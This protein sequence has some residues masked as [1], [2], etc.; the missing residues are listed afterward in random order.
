MTM[1]NANLYTVFPSAK[2]KRTRKLAKK[3][4]LDMD[5]LGL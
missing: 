2:Y 4:G 1:S 5:L 3:Q